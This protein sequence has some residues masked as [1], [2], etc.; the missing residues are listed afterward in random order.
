MQTLQAKHTL[1]E[2]LPYFGLG[3][4]VSVLLGLGNSVLEVTTIAQLHDQTQGLRSII[5]K[6]FF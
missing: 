6:G 4:N 5:K 2:I 1:Q 3:N